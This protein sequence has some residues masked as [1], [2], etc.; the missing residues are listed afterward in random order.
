MGHHVRQGGHTGRPL[1]FEESGLGLHRRYQGCY[2]IDHT[3]AE[4]TK[5]SSPPGRVMAVFIRQQARRQVVDTG[6]KSHQ[7]GSCSSS[8]GRNQPSGKMVIHRDPL[9]LAVT[10][11]NRM[12][13][14]L[15]S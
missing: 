3:T 12:G 7:C 9:N 15:R 6:I 14:W 2:H 1:L 11:H 10:I 8:D 5:C 4:F 13:M